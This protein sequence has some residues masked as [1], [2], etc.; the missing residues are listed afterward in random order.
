MIDI[1][2]G[3]P[4]YACAVY[5]LVFNSIMLLVVIKYFIRA[6]PY[7]MST[8]VYTNTINRSSNNKFAMNFRH[9]VERMTRM[10]KEISENQTDDITLLS[11]ITGFQNEKKDSEQFNNEAAL[12]SFLRVA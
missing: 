1:Y 12:G 5:V 11:I 8:F 3:V 10:I 4:A 7:P 2:D 6:I 9:S